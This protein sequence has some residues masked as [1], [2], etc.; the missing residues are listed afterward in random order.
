MIRTSFTCYL[1]AVTHYPKAFIDNARWSVLSSTMSKNPVLNPFA[2]S[3]G[4]P[5]AFMGFITAELS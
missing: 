2:A 1:V 4:T 3:L 5:E